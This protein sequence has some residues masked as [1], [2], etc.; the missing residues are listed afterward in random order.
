MNRTVTSHRH[1]RNTGPVT[2]RLAAA[3]LAV[4]LPSALLFVDALRS[5]G[6]VAS[7]VVTYRKIPN[8]PSSIY[9][10]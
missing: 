6:L 3:M 10:R 8:G 2:K 5:S 1:S 7:I 4:G 9:R